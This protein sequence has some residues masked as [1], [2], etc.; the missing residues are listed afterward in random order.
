MDLKDQLSAR[1]V[2]LKQ[3]REEIVKAI[4]ANE[5]TILQQR[6]VLANF[7]GGIA[8]LEEQIALADGQPKPEKKPKP[9]KE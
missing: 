8:I 6:T 3:D 1:L 5:R 4:V 7:D 2:K 9:N